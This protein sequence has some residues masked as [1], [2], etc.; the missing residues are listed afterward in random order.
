MGALSQLIIL[1][2]IQIGGLGFMTAV[3]MLGLLSAEEWALRA[4]SFFWGLRFGWCERCCQA[5]HYTRKIY[6]CCRNLWCFIAFTGDSSVMEY[7]SKNQFIMLSFILS[8]LF[9]TQV[10]L[11]FR[12]DSM[13]FLSIIVPCFCDDV[14]NT[15]G[16]GFPVFAN[17]WDALWKKSRLSHYSKLVLFLTFC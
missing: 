5:A 1:A 17:C 7:L 9:A 3:M 10:F 8:A 2:L 4:G 11:R 16:L 15:G 12:M 14:N 13:V 6:I